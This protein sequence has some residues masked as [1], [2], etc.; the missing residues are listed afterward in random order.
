MADSKDPAVVLMS[1]KPHWA[2][3]IMGGRKRVEF[4]RVR[5]GREISHVVVYAT[6]PVQRVV[7]YFEVEDITEAE[8]AAL[9]ERFATLGDIGEAAFM[10]YYEG[11]GEGVAIH[12]GRVSP[13]VE[14]VMLTEIVPGAVAPQSY[15]Y[16]DPGV[17]S[18]LSRRASCC[19]IR[20]SGLIA[21]T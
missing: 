17:I 18:Q 9:W 12:V 13:L 2:D 3:A 14:P 11:K 5:F 20:P 1:I 4:R 8:P 15:L 10:D 7:G 19:G 21:Y 16:A 6:S